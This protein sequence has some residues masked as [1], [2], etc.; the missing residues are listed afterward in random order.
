MPVLVY[1]RDALK[2]RAFRR[3]WDTGMR[4]REEGKE[5]KRKR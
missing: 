3:K 5:R 4:V 1:A 2:R